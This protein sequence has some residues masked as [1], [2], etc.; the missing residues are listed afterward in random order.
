M[1]RANRLLETAVTAPAPPPPGQGQE[2]PVLAH[3]PRDC[4]H[5][6]RAS[7]S[8]FGDARTR[9]LLKVFRMDGQV[10]SARLE[11]PVMPEQPMEEVEVKVKPSK[12]DKSKGGSL[13]FFQKSRNALMGA[14][15][16]VRRVATKGT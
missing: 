7:A 13:N 16:E 12:K 15:D 8:W 4:R 9:E 6:A 14:A 11:T 1:D 2:D 10:E 5:G 3:G